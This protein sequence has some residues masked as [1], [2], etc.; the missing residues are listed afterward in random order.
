M[1]ATIEEK[2]LFLL[3]D[4]QK[5]CPYFEFYQHASRKFW[6]PCCQTSDLPT[7]IIIKSRKNNP[8]PHSN[9]GWKDAQLGTSLLWIYKRTQKKMTFVVIILLTLSHKLSLIKKQPCL[10]SSL[11]GIG[12]F[13]SDRSRYRTKPRMITSSAAIL[14]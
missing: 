8:K 3:M 6:T 10:T 12:K 4:S 5:T 7:K 2:N 14:L 13:S 1:S 9:S 11:Q